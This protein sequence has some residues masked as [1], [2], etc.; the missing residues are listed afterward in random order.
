MEFYRDTWAEIDLDAIKWNVENTI[1]QLDAPAFLYAV[2]KANAYGHGDVQVARAALEAGAQGLAVAFLDEAL[3]I[4]AAGIDAPMLVLGASRPEDAHLAAAEN[5]SVTVYDVE[6]LNGAKLAAGQRLSIH[7][8]CDTGMGRIGLKTKEELQ[9]LMDQMQQKESFF[10]EGIFTHFATADETETSYLEEQ[11][12][13]FRELVDS[14]PV[15]PPFIHCANSAATLRFRGAGC[16]TVRL[17]ISMYGL[18]PSTEMSHLLP[19]KLKPAFSLHTR[20]VHVKQLEPGEKVSYGA[21]YE[22]EDSEW[23]GTLPIGYADGW[24]RKLSGQEVLVDG[25]RVPIIGRI[26]M[27]QCMIKLPKA[28]KP[29]TMATL[30]GVQGQE[31]ISMEEVAAKRETINY[32]IPCVITSRVPRVY[33]RRGEIVS[34]QNPLL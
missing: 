34:V 1:K 4:R 30:I 9:Q 27:D 8:K 12:K 24:I 3:K 32:E 29:G 20:L 13:K 16:N 2:V 28:Y 23:V 7:I 26:C 21:T 11:I 5:I 10:F 18:T 19:F 31:N 17:G 22:A 25:K 33:K 15:K 14:L 6:W